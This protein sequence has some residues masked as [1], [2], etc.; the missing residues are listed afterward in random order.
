MENFTL[1]LKGEKTWQLKRSNVA[2]PL[3]GCTPQWTRGSRAVR[4]AAE[5]QAKLHA[6]HAAGTF[7]TP[8]SEATW[9]DCEEVTLKPGAVLYVPAGMWHRVVCGKDSISINISLMGSTW[10]DLV[11]DALRQRLLADSQARAPVCMRS[12][13]DGRAQLARILETAAQALRGLTTTAL[14]PEAVALPRVNR[15]RLPPVP[16]P[17]GI[18]SHK[19][20]KRDSCFERSPLAVLIR[21]PVDAN[22]GESDAEDEDEDD[23]SQAGEEERLDDGLASADAAGEVG[24]AGEGARGRLPTRCGAQERLTSAADLFVVDGSDG[25]DESGAIYALHSHFGSEDLGSL[26]RVELC[27]PAS[28]L[29]LMEWLRGAPSSFTAKEAWQ[30]ALQR[31]ASLAPPVPRLRF[32]TAASVIGLLERNGYCQRISRE[33]L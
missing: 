30:G 31:G 27:A 2:V 16:S 22:S 29:D 8:P 19:P 33:A 5:Q 26:L 28:L 9:E 15:V 4:S 24:T 20:I 17:H 23:G 13:A 6:Q 25:V 14:L 12:I 10:A 3:R 18:D 1:Q 32:E 7:D 11:A 21:L